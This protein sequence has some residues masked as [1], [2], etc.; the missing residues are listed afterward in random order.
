MAPQQPPLLPRFPGP[1]RARCPCG[2]AVLGARPVEA[3]D[4]DRVWVGTCA[5]CGAGVA[6]EVE[7]EEAK[8]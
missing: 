2:G 4:A 7:S 1:S 6:F 5:A 8:Q 3:L